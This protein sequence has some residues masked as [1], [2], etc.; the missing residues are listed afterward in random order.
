MVNRL[1]RICYDGNLFDYPL[2][3]FDSLAKLGPAEAMLCLMSYLHELLSR[4]APP[5]NF[6]E[7]A[8]SRFGER[9]YRIFFRGYSEKLWGIPCSQLDSDFAAQ[10]IRG[11]SVYQALKNMLLKGRGNT[12]ATLI[13]RFAYPLGGTGSVYTTMA[14]RI[15]LGGGS[16]RLNTPVRRVSPH[17]DGKLTLELGSGA[18]HSYAQVVSSMPL[19]H[20]MRA[21]PAVPPALMEVVSALRF[22]NTI[23]VYL[24]VAA[25]ALFPDQ[26]IYVHSTEL[27]VGRITN[28]RNWVPE[29]YGDSP[30]TILSLELWCDP[31]D[32][33]W[34][35]TDEQNI[36][37]A[38]RDLQETGLLGSAPVVGGHVVRVPNCYPVYD[39]GYRDRIDVLKTHLEKIPGLLTIGRGGA[40]RYNNQ[41]HSL[42]MGMLAAENIACGA[43]HDLWS[44]NT[45]NVYQEAAL[46]S[47]TG[48]VEYSG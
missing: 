38:T 1:T 16:V 13:D 33:I 45:E 22:R 40:F 31:G 27:E 32:Q 14:E 10:R 44:T 29:L 46:I 20:L 8:C 48:L 2:R 34:C 37:R 42:L 6:E 18:D 24:R 15:R 39:L 47:E 11:F 4:R 17:K 30:D 19:T 36:E 3:L 41:D 28:F 21:L 12:H 26:W 43:K 5:Q 25:Q 9:L 23:L 35:R 7:W